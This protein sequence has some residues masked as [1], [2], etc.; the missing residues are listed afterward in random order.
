LALCSFTLSTASP[1]LL[2]PS[3]CSSH[4][5]LYQLRLSS[6][7]RV[8]DFILILYPPCTGT[9]TA[10]YPG[11]PRR[12]HRF[13]IEPS[14]DSRAIFG[15]A[16]SYALFHGHVLVICMG[17]TTRSYIPIPFSFRAKCQARVQQMNTHFIPR[18]LP[19]NEPMSARLVHRAAVSPTTPPFHKTLACPS[20]APLNAPPA[21]L[22][23]PQLGGSITVP[24]SRADHFI[25]ES[26]R[27]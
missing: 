11:S 24:G 6:R 16:T 15:I 7:P 4:C 1:S 10:K 18:S 9:H 20:P 23:L 8:P 25:S 19:L 12:T 27:R 5:G 3:A 14:T 22:I 2:P 13:G 21:G 26:K 17:S